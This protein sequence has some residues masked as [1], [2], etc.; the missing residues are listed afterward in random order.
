MLV[1]RC[2]QRV[3]LVIRTNGA[4]VWP[5]LL[6]MVLPLLAARSLVA[7]KLEVTV[8]TGG[9][10]VGE[11]GFA[12]RSGDTCVMEVTEDNFKEAFTAEPAGGRCGRWHPAR[13][14]PIDLRG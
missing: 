14:H 8:P 6:R 12:C 11:N 13:V 5:M 10:V 1:S 2:R 4:I 7:C 9:R 3:Q